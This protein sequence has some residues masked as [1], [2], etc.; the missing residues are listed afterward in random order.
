MKFE[1]YAILILFAIGIEARNS[2][3]IPNKIGGRGASQGRNS[4]IKTLCPCADSAVMKMQR[5]LKAYATRV[6]EESVK[7]S[8]KNYRPPAL[9]AVLDEVQEIANS[10]TLLKNSVCRF[11]QNIRLFV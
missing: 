6:S 1:V 5:V 10:K 8:N 9:N 3:R 2:E 11:I 7:K 4:S